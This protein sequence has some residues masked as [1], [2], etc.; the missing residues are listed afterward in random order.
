MTEEI[1]ALRE[2]IAKLRE[3]VAVLEAR[4]AP[5]YPPLIGPG[6]VKSEPPFRIGSPLPSP[7]PPGTITCSADARQ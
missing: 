7:F 2:E 4:P 1:Q 6:F 5:Y 3:R